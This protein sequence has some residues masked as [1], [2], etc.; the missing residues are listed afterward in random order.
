[1]STNT[2]AS[3]QPLAPLAASILKSINEP[4]ATANTTGYLKSIN[5]PG[6][7]G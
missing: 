3:P 2:K 5:E 4:G 6:M 7:T 1:M